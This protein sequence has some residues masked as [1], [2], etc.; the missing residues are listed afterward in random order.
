MRIFFLNN[1]VIQHNLCTLPFKYELNLYLI[2]SA[3]KNKTK[4][5]QSK[6][7]TNN[8]KN[9]FSNQNNKYSAILYGIL[10]IYCE[11]N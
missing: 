8:Q 6:Q 1:P 2:S 10:I 3:I 11:I 4:D 7:K 9:Q 5:K